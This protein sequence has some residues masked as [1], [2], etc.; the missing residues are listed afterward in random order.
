M[1][2]RHF[3]NPGP[4]RSSP[5]LDSHSFTVQTHAVVLL[6]C[7]AQD[8]AERCDHLQLI[9]FSGR[10]LNDELISNDVLISSDR[11]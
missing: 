4:S 10:N 9:V 1:L 8:V 3:T 6:V 2:G 7:R 5:E 11:Q